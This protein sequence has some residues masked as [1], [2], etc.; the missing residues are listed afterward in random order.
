M[1]VYVVRERPDAS[2]WAGRRWW[3]ALDAIVWPA[4]WIVFAQGIPA[5]AGGLRSLVVMTCIIVAVLRLRRAVFENHRYWFTTWR[6][7]RVAVVL[8]IASYVVRVVLAR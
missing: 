6:W 5:E 2:Y 1:W 4:A 3:A 8:I 7:G